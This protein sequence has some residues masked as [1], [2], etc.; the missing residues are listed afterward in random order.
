MFWCEC[1]ANAY[2]YAK[3]AAAIPSLAL[4][5]EGKGFHPELGIPKFVAD[6]DELLVVW[7]AASDRWFGAAMVKVQLVCLFSEWVVDAASG[8][9]NPW[10][11]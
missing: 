5:H 8:R 11:D 4:P 6:V 2:G 3:V 10:Q 9:P 7:E 1:S